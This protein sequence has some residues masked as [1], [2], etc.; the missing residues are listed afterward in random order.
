MTSSDIFIGREKMGDDEL[1]ILLDLNTKGCVVCGEL[2]N[3]LPTL[4]TAIKNKETVSFSEVPHEEDSPA[5][6]LPLTPEQFNKL[7]RMYE[8]KIEMKKYPNPFVK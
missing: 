7:E 4:C 8:R 1:F 2:E 5:T 3:L 6:Y